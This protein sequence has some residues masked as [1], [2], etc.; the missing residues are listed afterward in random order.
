MLGKAGQA[1]WWQQQQPQWLVMA[2]AILQAQKP[3]E[4]SA[5][6][7][8]LQGWAASILSRTPDSH[9]TPPQQ[10]AQLGVSPP[11]LSHPLEIE[12]L[13]FIS[14]A[15]MFLSAWLLCCVA[16]GLILASIGS[17]HLP[18]VTLESSSPHQESRQ[19]PAGGHNSCQHSHV[20]P[21]LSRPPHG[22]FI[23][24]LPSFFCHLL[25]LTSQ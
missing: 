9:L 2:A 19:S 8:G 6:S 22:P 1:R 18:R 14:L 21:L 4:K 10:P 25:A 23:C 13:A 5:S 3:C 17:C 12:S 15:D 20:F 24:L 11:S 16:P 7:L